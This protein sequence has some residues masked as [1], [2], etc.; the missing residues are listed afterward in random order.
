[1]EEE[2]VGADVL[3]GRIAVYNHI[4]SMSEFDEALKR[5]SGRPLHEVLIERGSIT[6]EQANDVMRTVRRRLKRQKPKGKCFGELAVEAGYASEE[7]VEECVR[8][9]RDME[10]QD[11]FPNLGDIMVQKG[12]LTIKQVIGLLRRQKKSILKCPGC[13]KKFNVAGKVETCPDCGGKLVAASEMAVVSVDESLDPS[14]SHK[15]RH[16]RR[17]VRRHLPRAGEIL[18]NCKLIEKIAEGGMAAIYKAQHEE[19]RKEVAVKVL[20]PQYAKVDHLMGRF[21]EEARISSKLSHENIVHA[22]HVACEK[23]TYFMVMQYV[24]G[25]SLKEVI[26][27]EKTIQPSKSVEIVRQIA[28]GL[29]FAHKMEVVHRDI[30]PNNI[31]LARD[32]TVKIVDFGLTKNLAVDAGLTTEGMV[33]GTVWYMAPEQAEAKGIDG[34]ADLYSLGVTWF[35]MLTGDV[36]FD[37]SSP[38]AVLLKHRNDR[39]PRVRERSPEVPEEMERMVS[40]LM[41]KKPDDRYAS[42]DEL[43]EELKKLT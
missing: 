35:E 37:G 29:G 13:G 2:P 27:R 23:G 40:T 18:G 20:L 36:P 43:I 30:K 28:R 9:Q 19:L 33:M 11:L 5:A 7:E 12:Y 22:V 8:I 24:E 3:F 26:A 41:E 32:G 15:V 21:I 1:M 25:E 39:S 42:A 31:M 4:I 10:S 38:W 34:R 6:A 14:S 17:K 16:S